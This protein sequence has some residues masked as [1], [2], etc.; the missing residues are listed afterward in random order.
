M[1]LDGIRQRVA[2]SLYAELKAVPDA[3]ALEVGHSLGVI[4]VQFGNPGRLVAVEI[5]IDPPPWAR[6]IVSDL[7]DMDRAPQ[8]L[9]GEPLVFTLPDDVYFEYAFIDQHG[10]MRADP[11]NPD[12]ADNPWYPEVSAIKGPAY[13]P[14]PYA[15]PKRQATGKVVRHRLTS[16]ALD[17]PRRIITYTP[18]GCET[19]KL[20]TL[21]VQD[22]LAYYR[23]G[24]LADVLEA[25]LESGLVR[26]ARLV[27]IEPVDRAKEYAYNQAYR[28]FMVD[29]LLPWLER[30]LLNTGE[31][32]A[33]GAS[34]GGLVSAVLALEHPELFQAVATQSG[35]FLGTPT[36]PDYYRSERS[37]VAEQLTQGRAQAVR[38][39]IDSG[40]LEWLYPV[41]RRV[42][43]ALEHGGY[44]YAYA[45]RHAGHNWINWR[46]GLAAAL[47]Y[48][49]P[50]G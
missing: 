44:R 41:N 45:E 15:V 17:Q 33:L 34:L 16:R 38:W 39:Y 3:E 13:R 28:R 48:V 46:N 12:R 24:R 10:A 37:W 18:V 27:F 21:Y 50:P 14:D 23:I 8:P 32:M 43:A 5:V 11:A 35:A 42:A 9:A 19:H 25:L 30:R 31:R 20:P 26:P 40:T 6:A 47:R 22:G 29:E 36:D 1:K 7:T 2:R 49:L 4:A